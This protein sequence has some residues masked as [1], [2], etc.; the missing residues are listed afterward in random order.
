MARKVQHKIRLQ[1]IDAPEKKQAFGTKS[2]E[3]MSEKVGGEE[4]VVQ[5]KEKDR[6][7]RILGE[8]MIGDVPLSDLLDTGPLNALTGA[9]IAARA[10]TASCSLCKPRVVLA[11]VCAAS[12]EFK[13]GC[14]SWGTPQS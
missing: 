4:V 12:A 6:Y 9:A 14:S 3:L 2:K 7:G 5:W 13:N 1:G 8:V 10:A 11:M